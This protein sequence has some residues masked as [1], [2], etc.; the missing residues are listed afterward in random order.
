[1]KSFFYLNFAK[2]IFVHTNLPLAYNIDNDEKEK[3][4]YIV[5]STIHKM[6]QLS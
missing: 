1:M 3:I 5:D 2:K 6:L 4:M